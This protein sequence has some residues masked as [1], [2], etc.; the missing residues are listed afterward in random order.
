MP[1]AC[2]PLIEY[3]QV[4]KN[5]RK[6][7]ALITNYIPYYRWPVLRAVGSSR[8][9]ELT[10]YCTRKCDLSHM[11]DSVD[12]IV[13]AARGITLKKKNS[14]SDL[15]VTYIDRYDIPVFLP[16]Q[17]LLAR[18]DI[19]VSGN[20]G[21]VSFLA[22]LSAKIMRVPFVVWTEETRHT[23][24]T[25]TRAQRILRNLIL[26]RV[27]GVLAWGEP[28]FEYIK[29]KVPFNSKIYYCSQAV[30]N[31]WWASKSRESSPKEFRASLGLKG[32]VFL[33]VGRLIEGK[34]VDLFLK[35]WASLDPKITSTNSILIVGD[36]DKKM[37]LESLADGLGI[38]NISFVG[39]RSRE[40]LP[41]VYASSDVF[42]FP[43]LVDVW[44]MVV[45]EAMAC[46]L[47][48]LGSRYAGATIE[49]VSDSKN[50]ETIDPLDIPSFADAISRWL[51]RSLP[52]RED[53]SKSILGYNYS[54]S[55]MSIR[56]MVHDL[57]VEGS[58]AG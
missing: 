50:G 19:I 36:G 49:L 38:K 25:I 18:P 44:G 32:R 22:M 47:P 41:V 34:G 4:L 23:A 9:I 31:E 2:G 33:V 55:V 21:P 26:P 45:N 20:M 27:D 12:F 29:D 14:Y 39:N 13:K 56:S 54:M 16:F 24:T 57:S 43:S 10:C 51:E 58:G 35:A 30:D 46:G 6:K 52:D 7:L 40:E 5:E 15:G 42:V 17:L 3:R 37:E 53:I 48:V 1:R 28:A 11:S 8:N